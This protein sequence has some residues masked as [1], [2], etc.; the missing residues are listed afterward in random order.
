MSRNISLL[1]LLCLSVVFF[2]YPTNTSPSLAAAR[3]GVV[4][5]S[6]QGSNRA[7]EPHLTA[8]S[9][10]GQSK[11]YTEFINGNPRQAQATAE[12]TAT[13][14]AGGLI[15]E[16]RDDE[17]PGR[18]PICPGYTVHFDAIITNNTGATLTNVTLTV[19]LPAGIQP[20]LSSPRT[21]P[22]GVYDAATNSVTWNIG[23]LAP[24]QQV[25]YQ[26]LVRT[27]SGFPGGTSFSSQATATG[28]LAATVPQ[29]ITGT[30]VESTLVQDCAT[31][32]PFPTETPTP[33]ATGTAT[34]TPTQT[35]TATTTPPA[36]HT[37]TA[38]A[39]PSQTATAAP[40][41]TATPTTTTTTRFNY[42]IPIILRD[43]FTN[44]LAPGE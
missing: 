34:G 9:G 21:T 31:A 19:R 2:L 8:D 28:Q 43:H 10:P 13:N 39:T 24:G 30:D 7:L 12:P 36:S 29:T 1:S 26:L 11:R 16:W 42:Y 25:L 40:T 6:H 22:G 15:V 23:T 35:A 27:Y 32:T 14:V 20:L 44:G 18:G 38:S 33:T 4:Q 3:P 5:A 17:G 41:Q 37:P